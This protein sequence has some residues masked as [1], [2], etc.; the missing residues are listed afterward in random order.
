MEEDKIK[1]E[2]NANLEKIYNKT[3]KKV[4]LDYE[5]LNI[6]T[7]I[8]QMMIFV[9][10]V[11]KE[12]IFPTEYAEGFIKLL[13]PLCP[14]ITEEIW[15]EKLGHSNTITYEPWPKYDESKTIDSEIE[16]PV[17]LNGKLKATIFA[18]LDSDEET[19]RNIVHSNNTVNGLLEGKTVVK[20]IFVKNKIYNI[21]V[22]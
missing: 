10:A 8:S 16:I 20:E 22:R 6:N 9:N 15:H 18:P 13:N 5:S 12:S 19:V 14:H 17:Q 11:N 3:V 21:V 2:E 7:A 1:D 4:T